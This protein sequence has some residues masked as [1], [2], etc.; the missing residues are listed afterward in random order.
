MPEAQAPARRL[1]P[2]RLLD[3][4]GEGGM[5]TVYRALDERVDRIVALKTLRAAEAA[6][7]EQRQRFRR[8]AQAVAQLAHP[9]IVAVHEV[10]RDEASGIDY[11]AMEYVDG[12]SLAQS[13]EN[14]E[15]GVDFAL[16]CAMPVASALAAAHAAG[17]VHR[18]LKPGNVLRGADGTIKLLDFGLAKR[19]PATGVG[20]TATTIEAGL[21]TAAGVVLGTP[22]YMA[23]EQIEG[24]AVDAR[25]D[26]FAL[27]LLL[28]EL[29][30]G[31][32]AFGGSSPAA[33]Q[34]AILRDTPAPLNEHCRDCP[35]ALARLIERCLAK[36]PALR[37]PDAGAVLGELQRIAHAWQRRHTLGA[38]LSR[39]RVWGPLAAAS[40]L[41]AGWL[42][43]AQWQARAA[44]ARLNAGLSQVEQLADA[45]RTVEAVGILLELERAFPAAEGLQPWWRDLTMPDDLRTQPPG[46]RVWMKPYETPQAPWI[47]LGTAGDDPVRV[48]FGNKRWRVELAGHVPLEL[49]SSTGLPLARL[50][51]AAQA[52]EGMVR[53]P[54]G[55]FAYR[56]LL[57]YEL[58]D[59]W[60]DRT[61][62]RNID[63]QRFVDAGGY[64]DP[65][66]WTQPFVKDGRELAF[67]E[68]MT[69]LR[70][71][72][73]R[74]GPAGWELGHYPD[75]Q[76]EWPV[77]GVSWY[78]AMAYAQFA[79]RSLPSA[80][81]WMHA[82]AHD[83]HADVLNFGNFGGAGPVAVATREAL[84]L[85]GNHDLAGNVA[86]WVATG[87][88]DRRLTL[89]GHF[90]SPAYLYAD[91]DG[92]D[93]WTRRAEI[94]FRC[95]LLE[96]PLEDALLAMPARV[97]PELPPPI[98]DQAFRAI[99]EEFRAPPATTGPQVL[100][101]GEAEHW[102]LEEWRLPT[103]ES[104]TGFRLR[105]Y[106][107][108]GSRAPYQTVVFGP[109]NTARLLA[110]FERATTR[111]FT[112]LVRAGRAVA[113]AEFPGTYGRRL[114]PDASPQ[115]RNAL[116][117]QWGHD[118]GRIVDFLEE[119]PKI[120]GQRIAWYGLS[121]GGNVGVFMLAVEPRFAT[122]IL[123][124]AGL[125]SQRREPARD[126]LHFAPRVRMPVL[127]IGGRYDFQNPLE[128]SQA[129]LFTRLGSAD[130]QHHVFDGGHVPPRPQE[131]YGVTL[132][133][134]DAKLGPVAEP[135]S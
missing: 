49:A 123:Q 95:A 106:L 133:W 119:H 44:E 61:E 129:P 75:G 128:S 32:R 10:G 18:D 54:G 88:I 104:A 20:G 92:A 74:P 71:S 102:W 9:H 3:T 120:D 100:T 78:E 23:P 87:S 31:T 103:S 33:M 101:R 60:L 21:Q 30:T 81:H 82:A 112:F 34:G 29:L 52:P 6:D 26:V 127:L 89:G 98:D 13:V 73:G 135:G 134:L 108:K 69:L 65:Q 55:V 83:L 58:A 14:G 40:L 59:F 11:I 93:P 4:V 45:G 25:T 124:A 111:E 41:L 42:G 8:E 47:E 115:A 125:S 121:L 50:T 38:Q 28:Y 53:V 1:G 77:A 16:A 35:P 64:R 27:G 17:I 56:E 114:P 80:H 84:S 51:P 91:L 109:S 19:A 116:L 37:P 105:L 90:G 57:G 99:A 63:F 48:P 126:A 70:D 24:L 131:I 15:R 36:D 72:T 5:G 94:G 76:A 22:A 67:E 96:A 118:T 97:A 85:Y 113:I 117:P 62:V 46:A 130:K 7:E 79:G 110:D 43:Y 2:Y 68:A 66:Y 39:P 12:R 122:G 107:P 86:E 132:D